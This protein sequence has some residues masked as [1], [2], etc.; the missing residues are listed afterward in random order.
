M[1]PI[2]QV[3]SDF[4]EKTDNQLKR[5]LEILKDLLNHAQ[6]QASIIVFF[7]NCDTFV[8]KLSSHDLREYFPAYQGN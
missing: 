3:L 5:S 1:A 2:L 4:G 8:S 6:Q 7:M